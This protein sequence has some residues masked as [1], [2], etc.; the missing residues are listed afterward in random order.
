[1][2][3]GHEHGFLQRGSST[4]LPR[5]HDQ[6]DISLIPG[7]TLRFDLILVPNNPPFRSDLA[8]GQHQ[9]PR[10]HLPQNGIPLKNRSHFSRLVFSLRKG[11]QFWPCRGPG[12]AARHSL[13]L[14]SALRS[15]DRCRMDLGSGRRRRLLSKSSE[16]ARAG[17]LHIF[18]WPSQKKKKKKKT[19]GRCVEKMTRI[20][21]WGEG[22]EGG[23]D[24]AR[25]SVR[26]LIW[27]GCTA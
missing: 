12:P 21:S 5:Q 22:G 20:Q 1:M 3:G 11:A 6:L 23:P 18:K 10:V 19:P 14:S 13:P 15:C 7:P 16:A 17:P 24:L 9:M 4:Y 25:E 26:G 27:Q 2:V 8:M